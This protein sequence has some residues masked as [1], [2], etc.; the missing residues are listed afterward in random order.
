MD[1][2][3]VWDDNFITD[4]E[5]VDG[6]HHAL[7][8][9]F[10]EL[11]GALFRQ[12]QGQDND[13]LLEDIYRRLLAYTEYHFAEEEDLMQQHGLDERHM[14]P[15]RHL[16][17]QFVEQVAL[18]WRQRKSMADPGTTLVGFLTSWLGLHILGVDQSMARQICSIR[19]GLSP[20]Q[21][22][23]QERRNNDNG[24]QA[25]LKM[26]GKLYTALSLQNMQLAE[27][28]L[29]LEERVAE[30]TQEL[31]QA[32]V[33]LEAMSRTDGL[34]QIANRAY[35]EERLVQACA[36]A[37][38]SGRPVGLVMVDVDHFKR[39]NDHHGHQQGDRC[40]QAVAQAL[41]TSVHRVSDVVARYG[42]EEFAVILPDTDAEG[43]LAV[44]R[45]IVRN[46]R[47]LE[48]A[49]GNS[50]VWPCVTVS[51]GAASMVPPA[52]KDGRYGRT[53]LVDMADAALYAAKSLG[54]NGCQLAAAPQVPVEDATQQ[55]A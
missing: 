46:V 31:A 29:L 22:F 13:A 9:L 20:A 23:D 54:R 19:G 1:T 32:N 18:L 47:L 28:N 11:S 26:I 25:L 43:A 17:Q 41:R 45:Q 53:Q 12:G 49:H 33:R 52:S 42:G 5:G 36:Q 2:T 35:F 44:A 7:V 51:A 37:G 48:L 24:T 55:P 38:R 3:F 6:Q 39:Y 27:S 10:N 4:L 14:Q 8:D 34:L 21:A 16:H 30:R 50:P 15:H 40:L